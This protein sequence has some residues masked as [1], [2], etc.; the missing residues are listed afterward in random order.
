MPRNQQNQL[1]SHRWLFFNRLRDYIAWISSA[2]LIIV[3]IAAWTI[4][5]TVDRNCNDPYTRDI[6]LF[7]YW[8][9][10]NVGSTDPGCPVY[11]TEATR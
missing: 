5:Y 2:L 10:L 7:S 3:L 9:N 1:L 4:K 11:E 8:I 6:K